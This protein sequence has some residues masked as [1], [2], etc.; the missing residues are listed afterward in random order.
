[1]GFD[2]ASDVVEQ[3]QRLLRHVAV[4]SVDFDFDIFEGTKNTATGELGKERRLG[5]G[6]RRRLGR[7]RRH[8]RVQFA[9]HVTDFGVGFFQFV[10]HFVD[11]VLERQQT[12]NSV[13]QNVPFLST[14]APINQFQCKCIDEIAF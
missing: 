5:R 6:R 11:F 14:S 3:G 9:L 1:M 7:R 4:Q 2:L 8:F 10:H 13:V 12:G